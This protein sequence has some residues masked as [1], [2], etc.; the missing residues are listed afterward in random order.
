MTARHFLIVVAIV[1]GILFGGLI[2]LIML[3]RWF[4]L[5][6]STRLN[7][8]REA[9]DASMRRWAAGTTPLA[10]VLVGLSRL[11]APLAI[12]ALVK[13]SAR[14]PGERWRQLAQALEHHWWAK[15]VRT[16]TTSARWWKRLETARFLSVAAT[17]QNVVRLTRL[18]N[19][20]HP[21][22]H[23]AA[24]ACLERMENTSLTLTALDRLPQL[25][26][27]VQ[28]YYAAMLLRSR[29]VVVEHLQKRLRRT[30]DPALP[31]LAEFAARLG[32]PA[33][34]ERLTALA[35]HADPEVRIQSARALGSF[36]HR[37]SVAALNR[38]ATD[39]AWAVRAQAV[40]SLG[41][42]TDVST[43]PLVKAALRD[44]VWWVRLRA[45][46]ALMRFAGPGRNALLEAEVG[47][48]PLARAMAQLVLGL[49]AQ[50]LAEFA[51]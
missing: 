39:D 21:A 45:A 37:E 23:V 13:W 12:D 40:R 43:L 11:P 7:P 38:L 3:N 35:D 9:I 49:P 36:P 2:V 46:L 41:M 22:V 5:R 26:P 18:I 30:D 1:Q 20:P 48:D 50:A 42:I 24:V 19:D 17:P 31:R 8:R 34:R 16:N 6:R 28:A 27:T 47:A 44:D 25:A 14:V 10:G 33:L 15:L 29:P 51:A 4:R 32:E